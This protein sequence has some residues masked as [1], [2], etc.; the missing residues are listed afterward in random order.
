MTR[1]TSFDFPII[2]SKKYG[3]VQAITF[4]LLKKILLKT[5]NFTEQDLVF[6]EGVLSLRIQRKRQRVAKLMDD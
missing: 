1:C 6:D 3:Q 4:G 5:G 2:S